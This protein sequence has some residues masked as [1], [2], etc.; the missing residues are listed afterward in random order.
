MLEYP[1]GYKKTSST[2]KAGGK[3]HFFQNLLKNLILIK[4]QLEI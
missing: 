3:S 4:T 2:K 1:K